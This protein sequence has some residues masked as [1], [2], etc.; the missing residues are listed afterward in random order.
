[1]KQLA[2]CAIALATP[3]TLQSA[4]AQV[5]GAAR[6]PMSSPIAT[7]RAVSPKIAA[8]AP[9][10]Q[11][12]IPEGSVA[13]KMTATFPDRGLSGYALWLELEIQHDTGV[14]VLPGGFETQLRGA[15]AKSIEQAGFALTDPKGYASPSIETSDGPSGRRL[16]KVRIAV[17]ALPKKA[18][19]AQLTLPA[20]PIAMTRGSGEVI[21]LCTQPHRI[22]I[23]DP[24]ANESDPKPHSNPQPQRQLE[25]W[26]AMRN[27]VLGGLMALAV[28]GLLA[29]L[30]HLWRKRER[31]VAPAP[32]A[33]PPW[34]TGLG[35]GDRLRRGAMESDDDRK[36]QYDHISHAVRRYLGDRYDFDGL[37]STTAE[38]L[39]GCEQIHPRIGPLEDIAH[40]LQSVDVVKFANATPTEAECHVLLERGLAIVRQTVPSPSAEVDPTVDAEAEPRP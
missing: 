37:E 28:G 1:M 13:P 6:P 22:I 15:E 30:I 7:S 31:P 32:P 2:I 29:W 21:T 4:R 14:S 3:L 11:R 16:S 8:E 23:E 5:S 18:G 9:T 27:A 39:E 25:Q 38:I 12:Y 34:G 26:S 24:V 20:F 10:C 33:P 19:R 40:F 35:R 17:I 36:Q